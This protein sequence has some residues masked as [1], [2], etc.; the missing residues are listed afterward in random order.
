MLWWLVFNVETMKNVIVTRT[1][2]TL[3]HARAGG[4]IRQL[5]GNEYTDGV[6]VGTER[7]IRT[8]T[9]PLT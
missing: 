5:S 6:Q 9:G 7:E 4:A 2:A 1:D 3:S 8:K